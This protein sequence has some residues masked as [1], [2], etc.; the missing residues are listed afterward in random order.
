MQAKTLL[1]LLCIGIGFF[2]MFG[3]PFLFSKLGAAGTNEKLP[4]LVYIAV[5]CSG[6]FVIAAGIFFYLRT[7][8]GFQLS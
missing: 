4:R 3:V 2:N 5:I 6:L 1:F 8:H 7:P